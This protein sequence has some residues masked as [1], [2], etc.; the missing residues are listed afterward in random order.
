M[1]HLNISEGHDQINVLVLEKTGYVVSCRD[2]HNLQIGFGNFTSDQ[3]PNEFYRFTEIIANLV[4]KHRHDEESAHAKSI[5]L[6]T[7][8]PGFNLLFTRAELSQLND[9]LQTALLI[10]QAAKLANLS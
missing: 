4:N 8:Y 6:P 1:D 7:P 9:I 3:S 2:C 5:F 10:I